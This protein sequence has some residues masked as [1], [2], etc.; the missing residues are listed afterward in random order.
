MFDASG[1]SSRPQRAHPRYTTCER[2]ETERE[3]GTERGETERGTEADF[4]CGMVR[5]REGNVRADTRTSDR[6]YTPTHAIKHTNEHKRKQRE[7]ERTHTHKTKTHTRIFGLQ[8]FSNT[9]MIAVVLSGAL[10]VCEGEGQRRNRK[11]IVSLCTQHKQNEMREKKARTK[12]HKHKHKHTYESGPGQTHCAVHFDTNHAYRP[13]L[14]TPTQT[15][16]Q[17]DHA[18]PMC[19]FVRRER[20][21]E[22]RERVCVCVCSCLCARVPLSLSL[23]LSPFLCPCPRLSCA[24]SLCARVRVNACVSLSLSLS[25]F[26]VVVA[27]P[28]DSIAHTLWC[29]NEKSP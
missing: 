19:V 6:R 7:R 10:C 14:N 11:C 2:E 29:G 15:T 13:Y 26:V 4:V 3:T 28:H 27:Q 1:L 22:R 17:H 12:Q 5:L 8:Q 23:S 24:L 9:D 18:A 21:L 20:K 16:E 25:V